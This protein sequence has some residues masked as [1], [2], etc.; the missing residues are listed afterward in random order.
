MSLFVAL[1]VIFATFFA[2]ALAYIFSNL[3]QRALAVGASLHGESEYIICVPPFAG[4]R[5]S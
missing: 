4:A 5:D 3:A 1:G 2:F